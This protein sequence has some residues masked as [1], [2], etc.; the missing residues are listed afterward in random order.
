MSKGHSLEVHA[1]FIS[2]S[3]KLDMRSDAL[4]NCLRELASACAE[5]SCRHI[6]G[7]VDGPLGALTT[8]DVFEM[9][10]YLATT[11]PALKVALLIG[12]DDSEELQEFF[13]LAASNRGLMIEFFTD[14]TQALLWLGVS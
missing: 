11:I 10:T 12:D 13:Q 3:L 9:A 4:P 14:R 8:A 6:L 7:H 5:Y 2:V 1:E